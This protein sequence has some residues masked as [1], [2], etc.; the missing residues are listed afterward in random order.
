MTSQDA[1]ITVIIVLITDNDGI[2]VWC[3]LNV[4]DEIR[5]YTNYVYIIQW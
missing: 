3:L 2:V 5:E 4:E 1:M